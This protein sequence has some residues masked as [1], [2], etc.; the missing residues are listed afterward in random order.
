MQT[1]F[2]STLIAARVMAAPKSPP[3]LPFSALWTQFFPPKPSYTEQN[4]DDLHGKV[5]A[6]NESVITE[7]SLGDFACLGL[8]RHWRQHGSGKEVAQILYSKNAKVY[9]TARSKD[10]ANKA[11]AEIKKACPDSNGSLVYLHLDLA[12]LSAIKSSVETFTSQ[13]NKLHVLFNN[14]G[15]MAMGAKPPNNKTAQGH[16]IHMGVNALGNFLFTKLLT[17]TLVTTAKQEPANT[18]RIVWVSSLGLE[19][20]G[21]EQYGIRPEFEE[22]WPKI[23]P[24]ERHGMSKAA[25][26]LY[27][28][29]FAK[30]C[31]AEGVLSVPC[32][33]GNLRSDLYRDHPAFFKWVISTFLAYPSIYGA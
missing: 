2:K 19:M 3:R 32:N 24:M 33:P 22:Y 5:C 10:K 4:L 17:P 30:R 14:A 12:D 13:E 1:L 11:F 29:E 23:Q 15:V 25:N 21:E 16:E 7:A 9:C 28:I 6:S 8:Y 31:E 26:W 18:V 27:D 20:T